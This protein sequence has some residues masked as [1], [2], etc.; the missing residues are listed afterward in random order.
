MP[1]AIGHRKALYAEGFGDFSFGDFVYWS[2][3]VALLT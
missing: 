3:V 2:Y 1:N